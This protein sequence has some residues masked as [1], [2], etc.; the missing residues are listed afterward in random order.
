LFDCSVKTANILAI[1]SLFQFIKFILYFFRSLA[2]LATSPRSFTISAS[3]LVAS[4][5]TFTSAQSASYG[6]S[7]DSS[8]PS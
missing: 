4:F 5:Q 1:H 7:P 6:L 8:S 2:N 3:C